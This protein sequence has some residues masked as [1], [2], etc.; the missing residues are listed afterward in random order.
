MENVTQIPADWQ[1]LINRLE[2][3]K[4]ADW[5]KPADN[6]PAFVKAAADLFVRKSTDYDD[7]YIKGLIDL[8]AKTIWTWEIDKKLDR[9]RTWIKRG[10]LQVKGEGIRNSVD[11]LYIY[12][13]QY[14]VYIQ[15]V[16]NG[17]EDAY[18]FFWQFKAS[19][20]GFF[21]QQAAKL[22]PEEWIEFLVLKGRIQPEELLLQNVVKSYMG[23]TITIDDWKAAIRQTLK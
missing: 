23:G 1:N 10:E 6:Y 13:V 15:H 22:T 21:Y 11:D 5:T 12:T 20:Y 16:I 14:V 4:G 19:R 17:G 8:D 9:L 2:M 18:K 3:K 7:R